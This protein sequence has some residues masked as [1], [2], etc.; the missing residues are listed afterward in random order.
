VTQTERNTVV[1]FFAMS[2]LGGELLVAELFE[3]KSM[4]PRVSYKRRVQYLEG[5]LFTGFNVLN[6]TD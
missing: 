2:L 1:F 4:S 3:E 5:L 6:D